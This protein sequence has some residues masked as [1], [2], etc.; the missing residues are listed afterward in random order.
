MHWVILSKWQI[1]SKYFAQDQSN[2]DL[3]SS[4]KWNKTVHNLPFLFRFKS[5][6]GDCPRV[7]CDSLHK[8]FVNTVGRNFH[9]SLMSMLHKMLPPLSPPSYFVPTFYSRVWQINLNIRIFEYICHKYLFGHS[10]VSIILIQIYSDIRSCQICVY[11]YIRKFIRERVR[12]WKL[13]EYSNVFEYSYNFQYEYIFKH[14][15]MSIFCYKYIRTF[16]CII[17]YTNMFGHSFMLKFLWISH[18]VL[19][20]SLFLQLF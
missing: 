5:E 8:F 20:Y 4:L 15:F 7:M 12:A 18:S 16:V 3:L 19:F 9:S 2:I 11:E 6:S 13:F 17:F 1:C 14:S 10:F